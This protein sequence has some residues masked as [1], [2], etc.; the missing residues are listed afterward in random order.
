M[1][2][3]IGNSGQLARSLVSSAAD[4]GTEL[5][6][7]GRP[8]MDILRPATLEKKISNEN[9]E[10]II[11]TAA[12]TD[13]ER[14]EE[15]EAEAISLNSEAPGE[16]SVIAK[17]YGIPIIHISTD[18]VFDGNSS[19]DYSEIDIANP[20]SMYG[21]SKLLGEQ[22][23]A[24]GNARHLIF[25]TSWIYSVYGTNFVKKMLELA[26]QRSEIQVVNDQ[27]GN[28]T[29]AVDLAQELLKISESV[30]GQK[31]LDNI[32]W[33]LYHLTGKG[34]ASWAE[35][36]QKVMQVSSEING[37]TAQ[38]ASVTSSEF[39]TAAR[40]PKNSALNNELVTKTF[41]S[42]LPDWQSGVR[43]CVSHILKGL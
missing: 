41:G 20:L 32:P 25:R 2:L 36:A 38:I 43:R 14:A 6:S 3:V 27:F 22:S 31:N 1:I 29:Y 35:L 42:Q 40:R 18:Y 19:R 30:I 26:E 34:T 23:V 28:P 11:N 12:F 17:K 16:I 39:D 5:V 13:V 24:E 4:R 15:N 9:V 10:L 33:G 7:I 37:P 8:E 21:R